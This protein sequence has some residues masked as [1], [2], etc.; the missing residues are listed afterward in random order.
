MKRLLYSGMVP[1]LAK[2]VKTLVRFLRTPP[3]NFCMGETRQVRWDCIPSGITIC[4]VGH[5]LGDFV[6]LPVECELRLCW[7][8]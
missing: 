6:Q 7:L 5:L 4:R 8:S 3:H 2:C 1:F